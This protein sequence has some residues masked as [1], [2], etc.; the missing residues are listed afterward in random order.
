[1]IHCNNCNNDFAP[2]PETFHAQQLFIDHRTGAVWLY[3]LSYR[4]PCL[5]ASGEVC[6]S[7]RCLIMYEDTAVTDEDEAD[8]AEAAE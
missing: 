8:R 3:L 6:G 7:N 1:V 2:T 4:C 5:L